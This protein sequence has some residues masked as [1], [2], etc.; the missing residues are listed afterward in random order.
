MKIYDMAKSNFKGNAYRY[1]MYILSNSFAISSFFIFTNF[2][3]NPDIDLNNL[4]DNALAAEG[5]ATAVKISMVLIVLFSVFFVYYAT[6]LFIKSR[7]KE[8]GL[9]SLYGMTNKQ[10]RKYVFLENTL[11]GIVSVF[12]GCFFGIL[13]S[14]IFLMVMS[15]LISVNLKFYI[16]IKALLVTFLLFFIMFQTI[17]LFSLIRISDSEIVEQLKINKKPKKIRPF[18]KVLGFMGIVL[19][20]IGYGLAWKSKGY[21]VLL[22]MFPITMIVTLGTYF[23]TK[24]FSLFFINLLDKNKKIKYNKTNLISLSQLKFKIQDTSKVLFLTAILGAVTFTSTETIYTFY[25]DIDKI[26]GNDIPE[27]IVMG[28]YKDLSILLK[29]KEYFID[30]LEKVE[31]VRIDREYIAEY[32]N[33]KNL[34]YNKYNQAMENITIISE[35]S[36]NLASREFNVS[37]KIDLKKGEA[38]YIYPFKTYG[39]DKENGYGMLDNKFRLDFSNNINKEVKVVK[40]ELMGPISLRKAGEMEVFVL[41]DSDYEEIS[42]KV[43][44]KKY[45]AGMGVNS[46]SKSYDKSKKLWDDH[47]EKVTDKEVFFKSVL[48]IGSRRSFGLIL[49]IG[50]FLAFLFFLASG[51]IIYFKLFNEIKDD[52]KEYEILRKLGTSKKEI[53]KIISSQIRIIF[54]IPFIISTCHSFFALKLLSN[55]IDMN[56]LLNGIVVMIGYFIFQLLYYLVIKRLYIKKLNIS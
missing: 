32:V 8:F 12:I 48:H 5:A 35:N 18:S 51:S 21:M 30:E 6:S 1:L 45:M 43:D 25:N 40:E 28:N 37:D 31:G 47:I 38:I 19:L 50:F 44:N 39:E 46:L 7:G 36:Y 41:N 20:L 4:G 33:G 22:S 10:I 14:K 53:N 13:F 54:F 9:L 55:L 56:I 3:F 27:D 15:F 23:V 29:D 16:S 11:I 49:F 42:S 17:N 52:K 34:D 2:L 24:E 26:M